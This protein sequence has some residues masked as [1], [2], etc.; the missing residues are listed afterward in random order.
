MIDARL[1][2]GWAEL[3]GHAHS[4]RTRELERL[5]R[6]ETGGSGRLYPKFSGQPASLV[7]S[8]GV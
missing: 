8:R 7:E 4:F 5:A 3:P 1:D 2:T 6:H